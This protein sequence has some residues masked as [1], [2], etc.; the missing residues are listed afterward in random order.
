MRDETAAL[1][2]ERD[3][4]L[5]ESRAQAIW[6]GALTESCAQHSTQSACERLEGRALDRLFRR[7]STGTALSRREVC[8]GTVLLAPSHFGRTLSFGP[9]EISVRALAALV[10]HAE[11]A[12]ALII[13][14]NASAASTRAWLSQLGNARVT[15]NEANRGFGSACNQGVEQARRV[16]VALNT[17][18]YVHAGWL[19]PMLGALASPDAGAVVPRFL[20]PDGSLQDAGGLLA[21]DGT[22]LAYVDADDPD[23][24]CYR[25]RRVVD[26]GAAACMLIRRSTFAELGGFDSRYGLGYYED[27]DLC[28]RL[29]QS[30]LDVVYEPKATV[31]HVRYGSGGADT[32][33]ELSERNR[34]VFVERWSMNLA[35]R[36]RTFR[37]ASKQAVIAG[38]DALASPRLLICAGPEDPSARRLAD[39]LLHEWPRARLTWFTGPVH[40]PSFDLPGCLD[41]GVEVVDDHDPRSLESPLFHYDLVVAG[42]A[43][44]AWL[45]TALDRIQPQAPRV[46]L[47][48]FTGAP[49]TDLSR[50]VRVL[51]EA[52]VAPAAD[53]HPR[54]GGSG[55]AT[56]VSF[57]SVAS[58]AFRPATP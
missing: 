36:P 8:P 16:R 34:G 23:R 31:T 4:A 5:V 21:Q 9:C 22:V 42:S 35:G 52:A 46:S 27:S 54:A 19:E 33:A 44:P 29:A 14:H 11:A 3:G 17:D 12:F 48:E 30:G 39:M 25:F 49:E 45:S 10:A 53:L 58:A 32:A 41:C 56:A 47:S 55:T 15:L 2:A 40:P 7:S 28:L 24:L 43:L 6:P 1:R 51:A 13:V 26:Y 50:A 57:R 38:R 18:S 37:A 20:H